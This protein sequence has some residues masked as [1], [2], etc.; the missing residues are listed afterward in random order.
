MAAI[1]D[2]IPEVLERAEA[3]LQVLKDIVAKIP[4]S[5][6]R[7]MDVLDQLQEHGRMV[8][9]VSHVG[10]LAQRLP[11][12]VLVRSGRAGSTVEVLAG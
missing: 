9:V 4:D 3:T 11:R 2:R 10:E 7:A 8:G 5:L 1:R 6:D 12:Q